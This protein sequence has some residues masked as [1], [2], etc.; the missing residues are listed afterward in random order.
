MI[1]EPARPR[2]AAE[3]LG[4]A[5]R[6]AN[7][8]GARVNALAFDPTDLASLGAFGAD[9]VTYFEGS[10]VA[11]DVAAAVVEWSALRE[12]W[13]ILGPSTAFGREALAR[14]AASLE[15]GLVGD[16][17]ALD[18]LDNELVAAKPAFSGALVAGITCTSAIKMASVRPGVL[19]V[20]SP[21]PYDAP[22]T[23]H[24]I[25]RRGR[26]RMVSQRKDDDI[27]VLA[28]ADAVIGVGAAVAPSDYATLSAL[29]ALLGAEMAAT[30]K[31]TDRGWAPRSR[32]V[33]ITGR[34]IAPRLY[35][36][37]AL[38]GKFNHLVGV[39]SAGTILAINNDPDALVF[40][41]CDVGIVG[42][43]HEVVPAL[44][45]ALREAAQR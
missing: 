19:P 20:G 9:E 6:L 3:L 43:W 10:T 33:G 15:A 17:I 18:V 41:H 11:E 2:V 30:R 35:V 38:S 5:S 24:Q 12:V 39:R 28:R 45:A 42:D 1:V 44:A 13:A 25:A 23:T 22:V 29:A 40:A 7:D 14:M 8:V 27:E 32:Q 34:S 21:R 16:A 36:A 31:V 26:I 4:A 37:L